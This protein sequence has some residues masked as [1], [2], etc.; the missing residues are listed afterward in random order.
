MG[1]GGHLSG[2]PSLAY[3]DPAD[4]QHGAFPVLMRG[5]SYSS[6]G[7][8]QHSWLRGP[9]LA[10]ALHTRGFTIRLAARAACCMQ[11]NKTDVMESHHRDSQRPHGRIA[12]AH[13]AACWSRVPCASNGA[14]V[15]VVG[16]RASVNKGAWRLDIIYKH[17]AL[18]AMLRNRGDVHCGCGGFARHAYYCMPPLSAKRQRMSRHSVCTPRAGSLLARQHQQALAGMCA[19]AGPGPLAS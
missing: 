8:F 15:V 3:T 16:T 5:W 1:A 13:E 7:S 2:G 4:A 19:R 6:S 18:C 17:A 9:V 11:Q 10:G 12:I 14:L